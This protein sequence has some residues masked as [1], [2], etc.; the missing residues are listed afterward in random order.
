[1]RRSICYSEPSQAKAGEVS[2]WKFVFTTAAPLP[3]GTRLRFDLLSRGRES[4]DWQ[5]PTSNL[6]QG[7]NCI[8]AMLDN[9]KALQAKEIE[10]PESFAPLFEFVLP[11]TIEAGG[12]FMVVIGNP[13]EAK[14]GTGNRAQTNSQRRRP[15]HLLIDPTGKGNFGDP[16]VFT[17][18]VR[19]NVLKTIRILSPSFVVRNKRFDAIVR[20]EDEFGNLTSNAPDDT[21]IELS[22]EHLRENLNW[23]LFIPETGF[24]TLPNLYFNEAGIY[25]LRLKNTKTKEVFQSCPI[26]CF[27]ESERN[28][29]WGI[30]HGES[31]RIDSTE[32]IDSCLRHFRDDISINYFACS[33]F[34]SLEETSNEIWKSI[35]QAVTDFDEADRFST[36][37][38]MQWAGTPGKE[39]VRQFLFLKDNKQMLRRKD[40]KYSS[41]DKIYKSFTP[42]E[43]LS[44]PCFTMGKGNEYNFDEY[45]PEHERVAE[46][47]NAW[48]SSECTAKEG[49]PLPIRNSNKKGLQESAEGSIRKALRKNCRFG[50][51][52]GGLDDRGIYADFYQNGQE[53]YFPGMTAIIAQEHSRNHLAEALYNRSCYA[54][55]GERIIVGL[56]L[57]GVPMGKEIN[58]ADKPGLMVNRHLSG[59]AAG[60]T[61]LK[62]VEIIRNGEVLTSF[63]GT[64]YSL[65]FTYDDM[66]PLEKIIID[67][68]DKKPPFVYYYLR[69][70]QEDGHMAWSSPI[71]VDFVRPQPGSMKKPVKPAVVEKPIPEVFDEED[72]EEEEEDFNYDEK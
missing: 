64:G 69:V 32:N 72:E 63:K 20:F 54:T 40:G 23:K 6:K 1:M 35:A 29:Y 4:I 50:F 36:F 25:T 18:D 21:L 19:G 26:K 38:G 60:T 43:L 37:L 30:L 22:H 68:K 62:S 49:N 65:D 28:V 31:E 34:E 56:Y 58:S 16:E 46:I 3:K 7:S 5:I 24:I 55:T 66:V 14:K 42:K 12:N 2:N 61:T 57:A 71:W 8:W 53:Q 27:H 15:F 48:G 39:G 41:L 59:Y 67:A 17:L 11:S 52:A 47:Y 45:A 51:V 44:I 9:G 70:I 33:P 10:V 13:K